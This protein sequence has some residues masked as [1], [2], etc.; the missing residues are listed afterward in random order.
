MNSRNSTMHI[1]VLV[2]ILFFFCSCQQKEFIDVA[3]MTDFLKNKENG[4]FQTK[5]INGIDF[6]LMYQPTDLMVIRELDDVYNRNIINSLKKKYSENLYF[7]LGISIKGQ[8]LLN[9]VPQNRDDFGALVMQLSFE[10][11]KKI[12]L[13]TDIKD[14]I[15]MADYVYPRMYGMSKTTSILFVFPRNE[16]FFNSEY[17]NFTI[18][19]IG[20]KTGEIKFKIDSK[21]INHQPKLIFK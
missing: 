5:N 19:D 10:M 11:D 20:L 9:S 14:T 7:N 16:K 21:N 17:L 6:E 12:H 13:Y 1:G 3:E 2:F 15:K 4:Y 8:E 18:E